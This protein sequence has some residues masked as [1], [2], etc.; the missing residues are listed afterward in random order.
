MW[1]FSSLQDH[2]QTDEVNQLCETQ[3]I[4]LFRRAGEIERDFNPRRSTVLLGN[5]H[6]KVLEALRRNHLVEDASVP[7]LKFLF[8]MKP[9]S[10][11]IALPS[12]HF[13]WG[14]VRPEDLALVISR[15][16]IQRKE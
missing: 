8:Q 10:L 5:V 7:Y 11:N 12:E 13:S 6:E 1:L 14:L 4:A 3:L 9:Q 2:R 16:Q 15:T